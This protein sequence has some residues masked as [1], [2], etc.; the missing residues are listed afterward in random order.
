M[1]FF[2]LFREKGI[3]R[4]KQV[5]KN[6]F[7]VGHNSPLSLPLSLIRCLSS[8]L[9][10]VYQP[11]VI[12]MGQSPRKLQRLWEV[13]IRNQGQRL[14]C[15]FCHLTVN[16]HNFWKQLEATH[17][18]M[19]IK[20]WRE[21]HPRYG[22]GGWPQLPVRVSEPKITDQSCRMLQKVWLHGLNILKL[23]V[24]KDILGFRQTIKKVIGMVN[25]KS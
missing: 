9:L 4:M 13:C 2:S 22:R 18:G 16:H 5:N 14:I 7:F 15:I 17:Q 19:L 12:R 1:V 23:Y 6:W 11:Q 3:L 21:L 25:I 20:N 8:L 10:S 24:S